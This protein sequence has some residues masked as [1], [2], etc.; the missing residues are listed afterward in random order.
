M[1]LSSIEWK[2]LTLILIVKICLDIKDCK[3]HAEVLPFIKKEFRKYSL[4]VEELRGILADKADV[5]FRNVPTEPETVV[6]QNITYG[7]VVRKHC[8]HRIIEEFKPWVLETGKELNDIAESL[9][10][11]EVQMKTE[12]KR[13]WYGV[14][15][16]LT[17]LLIFKLVLIDQSC[18]SARMF[19]LLPLVTYFSMAHDTLASDQEAT[20]EIKRF[21]SKCI[22]SP[23]AVF[24]ALL[25]FVT[26]YS[27][28]DYATAFTDLTLSYDQGATAQMA[29]FYTRY[30]VNV[31]YYLLLRRL[32]SNN[33]V[34]Q[35]NE[36]ITSASINS[37][38]TVSINSCR[39]ILRNK[40]NFHTETTKS[41]IFLNLCSLPLQVYPEWYFH[42]CL[43]G[44]KNTLRSL[45]HHDE[46]R[47][48]LNS[49]CTVDGYSGLQLAVLGDHASV[50]QLILDSNGR[51]VDAFQ[52]NDL[53]ETALDIAVG[54]GNKQIVTRFIKS[55]HFKWQRIKNVHKLLARS[56]R[57]EHYDIAH[58]LIEQINDGGNV[59]LKFKVATDPVKTLLDF[60]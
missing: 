55:R 43:Y 47:P 13:L 25:V 21:I 9:R 44:H 54:K 53:G 37:D 52:E 14:A 58:F 56:V 38:T 48:N 35:M 60:I 36:I 39:I 15:N 32:S 41:S 33:D 59:P 26:A 22:Q 17:K 31:Y 19:L 16:L 46:H 6:C 4:E 20:V 42:A 51:E 12:Q 40:V 1:A 5:F 28:L 2:I 11:P 7:N 10:E 49:K 45:L 24:N 50:V 30:A 34:D 3:E 8:R 27:M 29:A 57:G 18:F 23:F